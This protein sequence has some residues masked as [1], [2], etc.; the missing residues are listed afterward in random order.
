MKEAFAAYD[1]GNRLRRT[2]LHYDADEMSAL[3]DRSIRTLTPAFFAG[4]AGGG[5][6]KADPIF[7]VGMPRAGST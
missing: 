3:V 2:E 4:L 6:N 1:D 7:I 5:C